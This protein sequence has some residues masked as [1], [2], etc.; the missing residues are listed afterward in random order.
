LSDLGQYLFVAPILFLD[1]LQLYRC[2]LQ[3]E[4]AGLE[5]QSHFVAGAHSPFPFQ[6]AKRH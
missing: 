1:R 4:R 6:G 3:Q 5:Q 2:S